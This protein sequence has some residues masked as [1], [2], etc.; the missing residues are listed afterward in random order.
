MGRSSHEHS[1][2]DPAFCR[3]AGVESR[4]RT[5]RLLGRAGLF[6]REAEHLIF[7]F[8]GLSLVM[9]AHYAPLVY[10]AVRSQI[11]K[12]SSSLL[13]AGPAACSRGRNSNFLD[14]FS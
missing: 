11:D 14:F 7:S 10:F 12:I 4:R 13:W 3:I 1:F 6:G 8:W 9:A 5:E 2:S